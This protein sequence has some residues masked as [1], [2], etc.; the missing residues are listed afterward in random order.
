M[1]VQAWTSA[2][3]GHTFARTAGWS[4]IPAVGAPGFCEEPSADD[5]GVG[6]G[7]EGPDHTGSS[8]GADGELQGW[9]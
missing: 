2:D 9:D 1:A 3:D 4:G 6:Q 5:D 8:L 7:D